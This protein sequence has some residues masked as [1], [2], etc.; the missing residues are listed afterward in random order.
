MYIVQADE[1]AEQNKMK[2]KKNQS[3]LQR[4]KEKIRLKKQ[5]KKGHAL[6]DEEEADEH[7]GS[8]KIG[9]WERRQRRIAA[10]KAPLEVPEQKAE[11][12]DLLQPVAPRELPE[13]PVVRKLK[14]RKDGSA[15]ALVKWTLNRP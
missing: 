10:S 3:P 6:K 13:M 4:L 12:D 5:E 1:D 7:S 2:K 15:Q 9:K 11:E 14:L 8:K